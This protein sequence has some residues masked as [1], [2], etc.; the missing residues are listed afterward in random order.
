MA[1]RRLPTKRTVHMLPLAD[2]QGRVR[3]A[4]VLGD[5][6]RLSSMLVGGNDPLARLAIHRRHYQSSLVNAL[7]DRYP[8]CTWLFGTRAVTDAAENFVREHPPAAPCIAEFGAEFPEYLAAHPGVARAPYAGA[9]A[10]LEWHVGRVSVEVDRAALA[11]ASLADIPSYD[12]AGVAL[13]LQPGLHYTTAEWPVDDLMT[14]FVTESV[15]ERFEMLRA[16]VC[17]ELRGARG[18]FRFERL[19]VGAYTFRSMLARG[20]SLGAAAVAAGD[21]DA[22]FDARHELTSVFASGVVTAARRSSIVV[23]A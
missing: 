18:D 21:A 5:T 19:S 4:V 22:S 6:G 20:D 13:T 3:D 1:L 8:A 23:A 9:F 14:L 2:V 11:I 12:L 10:Q 17:I 15:P 16:R 7:L